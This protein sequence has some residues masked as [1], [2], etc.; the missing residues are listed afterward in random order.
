MLQ[1]PKENV[2]LTE[3]AQSLVDS[4]STNLETSRKKKRKASTEDLQAS[5]QA[6]K[7]C[8]LL[9]LQLSSTSLLQNQLLLIHHQ[10]LVQHLLQKLLGKGNLG[11]MISTLMNGHNCYRIAT[12]L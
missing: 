3:E 4:I 2:E 7:V 12:I 5:R 6:K 8:H 1:P 10:S 11:V 9:W